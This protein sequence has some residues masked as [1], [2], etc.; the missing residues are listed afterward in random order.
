MK[1]KVKKVHKDAE[2]P[3][4]ESTGAA[5]FDLKAVTKEMKLLPVGPI[6]EYDTGLAFEIPKGFVGLIFQRSSI[7]TKTNISL[8]NAVGVIDSDY[9]GTVKFQF[10]RSNQSP[11]KDY[12]VGDRLGQMMIVPI[13]EIE[14]EEAKELSST[15]RNTGG[16]GSTGQ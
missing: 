12:N 15:E 14:L 6:V 10:R 3:K 7:T 16:F 8:G 9:R 1:V 11:L 2:L 5:C 13:P 4:Y